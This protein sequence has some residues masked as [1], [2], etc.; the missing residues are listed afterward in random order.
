GTPPAP[1]VPAPGRSPQTSPCRRCSPAQRFR[2]FRNRITIAG[3]SPLT[4][5]STASHSRAGRSGRSGSGGSSEHRGGRPVPVSSVRWAGLVL[6]GA[7]CRPAH[8]ISGQELFPAARTGLPAGVQF[9]AF[10]IGASIQQMLFGF[11]HVVRRL[12]T[13]VG[14]VDALGWVVSAWFLFVSHRRPAPCH[15][16]HGVAALPSGPVRPEPPHGP[17]CL[18]DGAGPSPGMGGRSSP[19]GT[20][21]PVP[22]SQTETA[23]SLLLL[24]PESLQIR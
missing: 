23:I 2:P 11:L 20:P 5:T 17:G 10:E 6:D 8:V 1:P 19:P 21:G 3:Q 4:R 22:A 13:R 24:F 7:A 15:R 16:K 14:H 12:D 18:A 9:V